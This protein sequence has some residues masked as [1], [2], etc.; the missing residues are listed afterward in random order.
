MSAH[1]SHPHVP[2]RPA[3]GVALMITA[4]YA[5]IELAGAGRAA[6]GD[7]GARPECLEHCIGQ[8]RSV[9]AAGFYARSM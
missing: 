8:G 9:R 1:H 2:G 6:G 4:G 3:F 7:F 5:V